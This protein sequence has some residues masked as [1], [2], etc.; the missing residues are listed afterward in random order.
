MKKL[1]NL[2][3]GKRLTLAFIIVLII[4]SLG[5]IAGAVLLKLSDSKYSFALESYGFAQGNIGLLLQSVTESKSII[6]NIISLDDKEDIESAAQRYQSETEAADKYAGIISI[7]TSEEEALYAEYDSAFQKSKEVNN[8]IIS[9]IQAGKKEEAAALFSEQ[10]EPLIETS[11]KNASALMDS[12]KTTGDS[13]SKSLT[14]SSTIMLI[15]IVAAIIISSIVSMMLSSYITKGISTPIRSLVETAN[16][17]SNGNLN[18]E[19]NIDSEDE[20]GVLGRAFKETVQNLNLYINDISHTLGQV[21]KGD[22]TV[23]SG[24][25]YKGSFIELQQSIDNILSSLNSTLIQI[26]SSASMVSSGSEQIASAGQSLSQGAMEQASAV[27]ELNATLTDVAQQVDN[28]AESAKEAFNKTSFIGGEIKKS[29]IK[30]DEMLEAMSK[31]S[32]SSKQIEAIMHTIED[33]ASQTNLLSLNAAIEAARAGDAGKGFA[34]VA[35]EIRELANQSSDAA[36]NTSQLIKS[37]L[38]AVENGTRIADETAG[39][40]HVVVD[41]VYEMQDNVENI[42][43]ASQKQSVAIN[44]VTQAV[45]QISSIV[46]NNSAAAQESAASSEELS[47][48]AQTLNSLIQQFELKH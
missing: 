31:I 41:G 1:N 43:S 4:T 9:L 38:D 32:E 19:V 5:S 37:S 20:L 42:S 2:K 44:E 45:D 48:Q 23:Q 29:N 17:I 28:N 35:D 24:V 30:M 7:D 26:E 40:L 25:R 16:E 8:Q 34:V 15:A 33:I 13:L 47:G 12:F 36:K 22:L 14:R 6:N 39:S 11:I 21:A 3:I 18:V 46:Q 10:G 27:E